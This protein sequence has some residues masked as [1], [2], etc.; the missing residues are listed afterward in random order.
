M[1]E[2]WREQ[3]DKLVLSREQ[4]VKDIVDYAKARHNEGFHGTSD[5]K[6]MAVVPNVV[7]EHYCNVNQITLHEFINNK[8]HIKRLV[9]SPEFSDLRV[10]PGRM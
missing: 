6:L 5:F 4:Y 1:K 3:D 2:T 10:A 7:I 9:N 8:E